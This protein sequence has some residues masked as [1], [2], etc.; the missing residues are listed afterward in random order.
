V[1]VARRRAPGSRQRPLVLVHGWL[2]AHGYF[3]SLVDAFAGE[4]ELVLIDL[5]GY[6]ESVRPSPSR[7]GYDFD[8]FAGVVGEVLDRLGLGEVDLLG[9]SMGGG[10]SLHTAA[11]RTDVA[12]LVMIA[13]LVYKPPMPTAA[14]ALALPGLGPWLWQR[15]IRRRDFVRRMRQD[16]QDRDLVGDAYV[17]WAYERFNRPGA[18][19]ASYATFALLSAIPEH[20]E[21]ATRVRQPTLIVWGD[22]DRML[23]LSHGRRLAEAMPGAHFEVIP[24]SGHAPFVERPRLVV[25]ALR[26]F[27]GAP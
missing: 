10:V 8:A 27:L 23:P 3:A 20:N 17:D 7:F 13:P 19:A 1:F 25:E 14:R 22:A 24:A 11:Q 6:G 12:R 18:R 21:T 26:R 4:R 15:A 5:P 9:H 16:H 2:M